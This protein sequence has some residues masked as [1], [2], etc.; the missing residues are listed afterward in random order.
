MDCVLCDVLKNE[1]DRI[2]Y[3]DNLVFVVMNIEP[4]KPEHVIILP[5]RHAEEC[6][7]L[8]PE[9][10]SVFLKM[11][12]RTCQAV[13]SVSGATPTCVING[14]AHRTQPHLHAHVLPTSQGLRGLFAK[15]EGSPERKRLDS[16]ELA[17]L[18]AKL[19]EVFE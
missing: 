7:D 2:V 13:A 12:D 9:E 8:T 1:Q 14:H 18:A 17:R 6:S 19:R 5:V 3:Q 16:S 4:L 10:A 15:A 11:I